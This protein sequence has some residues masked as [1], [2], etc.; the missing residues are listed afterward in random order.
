MNDKNKTVVKC[1]LTGCKYNSACCL[2]PHDYNNKDF[3]CTK[4]QITIDVDE[5][6][7]AG[8]FECRDFVSGRKPYVCIKC[9]MEENDGDIPL[10]EEPFMEIDIIEEDDDDVLY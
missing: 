5:E 2:A 3:Y 10:E 4:S 6:D 8:E 1:F 7:P 9:Q